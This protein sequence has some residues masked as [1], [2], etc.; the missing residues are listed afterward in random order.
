M[1]RDRTT[2][3]DIRHAARQVVNLVAGLDHLSFSKDPKIRPAVLYH[4]IIIGQA[5]KS[6]SD[7]LRYVHP[8]VPWAE[9]A[10]MRDHLIRAYDSSDDRLVWETAS[11][12]MP[13]LLARL[14][15]SPAEE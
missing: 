10:G 5:A 7:D 15:M 11:R 12:D 9:M 3:L 8:D 1:S 4:L 6:V 14:E 13:E 2:I